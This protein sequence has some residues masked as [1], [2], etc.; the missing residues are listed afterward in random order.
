M[1][2]Y[3]LRLI[4]VHTPHNISEISATVAIPSFP[5]IMLPPRAGR[6]TRTRVKY[7]TRGRAR[8]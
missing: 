2:V 3:R 7:M 8:A 4:R 5:G 1:H 6:V